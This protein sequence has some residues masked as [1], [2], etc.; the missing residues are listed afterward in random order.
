MSIN[1]RFRRHNLY[2]LLG[3][4]SP[5][6]LTRL[7]ID[8]LEEAGDFIRSYGFDWEDKD[9]RK[10][11][12]SFYQ[13]ALVFL[14][15][16]ILE[17]DEEVPKPIDDFNE[18]QDLRQL[19]V[20]VNPKVEQSEELRKMSCALLKI[21]HLFVHFSHDIYSAF[22]EEIKNQT[23]KPLNQYVVQDSVAGATY[24]RNKTESIK[25]YKFEQKPI[26]DAHSGILKLLA[27]RKVYALN[28]YDNIG[29]R[30]VTKN[31]FDTFR[32]VRF[33]L[34]N[35]VVS[36]KHSIPNQAVNSV[37]PLNLF[38]EAMD[39]LRTK[40]EDFDFDQVEAIID[41]KLEEN[42]DRAEYLV[43]ENDFSGEGYKF[44]KFISR[45]LIRVKVN[46]EIHRFFYPY[47]VQVMTQDDYLE[48]IQGD[49]AHHAYKQRQRVA[50]RRRLFGLPS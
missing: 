32:V 34:Q 21:M 27:K 46:G 38:F 49:Q 30:F 20:F 17:E 16:Q 19:F 13:K 42:Q 9:D 48:S 28:I 22:P 11:L 18:F 26:K 35:S 31:K 50:A 3:G 1:F 7:S 6:D 45:R 33:L 39:N 36:A 5:L 2:S 29:V 23:L 40:T 15:E 41:K 44:I 37:Y 14:K 25:L 8:S 4:I 47:E 12:L 24:L 43:K 10:L